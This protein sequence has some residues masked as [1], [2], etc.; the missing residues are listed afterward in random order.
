MCP[1]GRLQP[2]PLIPAWLISVLVF[3]SLA[4]RSFLIWA[5]KNVFTVIAISSFGYTLSLSG[6]GRC[7][8]PDLWVVDYDTTHFD[9]ACTKHHRHRQT[10]T[11]DTPN[12]MPSEHT[13]STL[14]FVIKDFANRLT[15]TFIQDVLIALGSKSG[16]IGFGKHLCNA[17]PLFVYQGLTSAFW[18]R[19]IVHYKTNSIIEL[20][21]F[22]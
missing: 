4:Q 10:I 2:V 5:N 15:T 17:C 12:Q 19:D 1:T 21:S 14:Y 9:I 16:G 11:D 8:E 13:M 18:L 22:K 3:L 7:Y 6:R 20:G